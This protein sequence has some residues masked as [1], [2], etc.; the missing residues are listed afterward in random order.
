MKDEKYVLTVRTFLASFVTFKNKGL[1]NAF[2]RGSEILILTG[3]RSVGFALSTSNS[4]LMS[5]E[6]NQRSSVISMR[7]MK[8]TQQMEITAPVKVGWV[9][10]LGTFR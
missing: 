9:R 8:S 6:M 10:S 7:Q 5:G 3:I 2:Y 1:L 4:D